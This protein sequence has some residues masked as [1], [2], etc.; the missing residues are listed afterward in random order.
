VIDFDS[1]DVVEPV[2]PPPPANGDGEQWL[3]DKNGDL[4][5]R[6]GNGRPGII[7]RQGEETPAQARERDAKASE[8]RPKPKPKRPKM[9]PAPK[10]V[11]LKQLE[12]ELAGALKA[13]GAIAMAFGDE[14]MFDHFTTKGPDLARQL[15]LAADH[16][17]WLR[18]QLE[19]MATGEEAIMKFAAIFNVGGA[20]FLYLAPP[21]VYLFNVPVPDRGRTMLGVPPRDDKKPPPYAA[22]TPP[23]PGPEQPFGA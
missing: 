4:Y 2:Q 6:R 13:P 18:K 10:K 1:A 11:D 17:P 22:P 8:K 20:L 14:W 19:T 15:V 23:T 21:V 3:T 5:I 12:E 9:P 7:K 16:N